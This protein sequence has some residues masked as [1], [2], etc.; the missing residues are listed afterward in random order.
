MG[1]NIKGKYTILSKIP[2]NFVGKICTLNIK[3]PLFLVK[4]EKSGLITEVDTAGFNIDL[5]HTQI[6]L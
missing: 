2:K 4:N 3:L 1:L 6:E 5:T